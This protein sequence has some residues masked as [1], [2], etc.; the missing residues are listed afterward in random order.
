MK[1]SV[2]DVSVAIKG[3]M[4][5]PSGA[6]DHPLDSVDQRFCEN[7]RREGSIVLFKNL[8]LSA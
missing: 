6:A 5:A 3:L 4:P 1:R 7:A 8:R 2:I